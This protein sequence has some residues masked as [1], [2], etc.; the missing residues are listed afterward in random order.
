MV[1]DVMGM[2]PRDAGHPAPASSVI[3]MGFLLT[4]V[5]FAVLWL[6]V[7]CGLAGQATHSVVEASEHLG[8]KRTARGQTRAFDQLR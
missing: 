5:R 6:V 1:N 8:S 2:A 4:R 7:A 3:A